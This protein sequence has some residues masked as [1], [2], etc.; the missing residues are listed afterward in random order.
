MLFSWIIL[1]VQIEIVSIWWKL[2][3]IRIYAHIIIINICK[4]IINIC[5]KIII[6][7][8]IGIIGIIR[9]IIIIIIMGIMGIIRIISMIDW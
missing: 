8:I 5:M 6:N 7:R 2:W 4:I 3:I 9:I 1:L